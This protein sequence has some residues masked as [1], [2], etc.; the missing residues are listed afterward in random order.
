MRGRLWTWL[1]V[2]A[3][4]PGCDAPEGRTRAAAEMAEMAG[5]RTAEAARAAR[6]WAENLNLGELSEAARGWLRKGA[7]ASSSGIEAVLQKGEQVVPVAVEIGRA[8]GGAVDTSTQFEPI[9]QEVPGGSS[10]LAE[11]RAEADAAIQG[12]PRVEV[13]D[14]LSVG[15]KQL[16]S[17]DVGHHASESAYLVMWR[18]HDRLIGF[19]LRSRRDV[20]LAEL[21]REAP[22]LVA[23]VRSVL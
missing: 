3:A 20:A 15:F 19:V 11:R 17:F 5:S 4:L 18:Q 7:E 9:Y 21:V 10:E 6:A 16:S 22:R 8:L 13:I 23:L 1:L 14:G 2:G 12:M